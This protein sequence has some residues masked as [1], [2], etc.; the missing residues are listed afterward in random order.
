MRTSAT[1]RS[2][3]GVRLIRCPLNT[4]FTVI[5]LAKT[6]ITTVV[7]AALRY[8]FNRSLRFGH[9]GGYS[10]QRNRDPADYKRGGRLVIAFCTF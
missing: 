4:G 10:G 8:I 7:T 1:V 5:R 6:Y 2:I 9:A 3:E